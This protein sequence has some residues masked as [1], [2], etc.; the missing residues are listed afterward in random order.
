M[1]DENQLKY[2][3]DAICRRYGLPGKDTALLEEACKAA[4]FK[5][6]KRTPIQ[7]YI[8]QLPARLVGP[9][10]EIDAVRTL[11]VYEILK[12]IVER[13]G[14]RDA[15]RLEVD[16]LPM[17]HGNA[18]ARH[19]HR[20]GRRRASLRSRSSANAMPRSL[21]FRISTARPS[22]WPRFRD[23]N[24]WKRPSTGTASAIRAPRRAIPRS[25]P[26]NRDGWPNTS[27]GCRAGS[28]SRRN[29]ITQGKR[30]SEGT[31]SATS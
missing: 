7:S 31:S 19:P 21:S 6:S 24:G 1:V 18:P 23:A 5:I 13:E 8:W 30:L 20:S 12:Q 11:E 28:R 27:T 10:A 16:L 9:Y 25:R 29:T 26:R 4:G 22:A 17:V 15:Y 14:T 2:S 3:L